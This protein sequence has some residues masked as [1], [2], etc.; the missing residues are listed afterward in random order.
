MKLSA[1][2]SFNI[3]WSHSWMNRGRFIKHWKSSL[4]GTM[5]LSAIYHLTFCEEALERTV[6]DSLS[7]EN[8][9]CQHTGCH[10]GPFHNGF[11]WEWPNI[12]I[13]RE[14]GNQHEIYD[15]TLKCLPLCG[16]MTPCGDMFTWILNPLNVL[17]MY[18][19]E[20]TVTCPRWQSMNSLRLTDAY[21][22]WFK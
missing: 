14:S 1:I 17:E 12:I 10:T 7:I 3:L 22:H 13:Q 16:I 20:I 18:T 5:K 4:V 11:Y 2:F 9:I 21:H 19:F 6:E 8:S 15:I